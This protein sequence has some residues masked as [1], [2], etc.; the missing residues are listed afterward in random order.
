MDPKVRFLE[1]RESTEYD[2]YSTGV[3]LAPITPDSKLRPVSRARFDEKSLLANSD[4]FV[5][6]HS[7]SPGEWIPSPWIACHCL[8]WYHVVAVFCILHACIK[9]HYSPNMSPNI[10]RVLFHFTNINLKYLIVYCIRIWSYKYAY[11]YM[12]I[13]VLNISKLSKAPRFAIFCCPLICQRFY[14]TYL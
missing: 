3:K 14:C 9:P 2:L 4:N 5:S 8:A 7:P 13:T 6:V 11:V 12:P 10:T 1:K